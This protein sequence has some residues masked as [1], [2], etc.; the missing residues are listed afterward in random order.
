[1]SI[2]VEDIQKIARLAALHLKPDEIAGYQ[3]ELDAIL[4]FVK[5]MDTIDVT[6]LDPLAHPLD[7]TQRLREDKVTEP[8][9]R[10]QFQKIAPQVEAGLYLVP[11]VIE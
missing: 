8:N 3:S 9:L 10:D 4:H 7:L 5:A 1:M 2:T 6:S 11:K